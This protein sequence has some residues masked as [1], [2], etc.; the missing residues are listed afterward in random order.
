MGSDVSSATEAPM[1]AAAKRCIAAFR[2]DIVRK[3]SG[4]EL[5][6]CCNCTSPFFNFENQSVLGKKPTTL[7]P[8]A[9]T[10]RINANYNVITY[11]QSRRTTRLEMSHKKKSKPI[12]QT[13]KYD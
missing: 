6:H 1:E 8:P 9:V 2:S 11:D 4:V 12:G 13:P 7:P 3:V 5:L 10:H